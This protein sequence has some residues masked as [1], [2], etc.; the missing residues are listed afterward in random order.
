MSKKYDTPHRSHVVKTRLTDEEHG[1]FMHRLEV[2]DMN[3]S[4]F[5]RKA[6]AG[7]T[8]KPIIQATY[9]N[10]EMLDALAK[11]IA[12][13]G[14]IGSNLNQIA[15]RLNEFHSPYPELADEVRGASADLAA[16]K[17]ELLGKVGDAIGNVQTHQL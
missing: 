12:E 15:R 6:I 5:I 14:K 17:F 8:I 2:F 10:D 16:L 9:V 1:E 7:A 4:E 3:Q 11:L 13:Y